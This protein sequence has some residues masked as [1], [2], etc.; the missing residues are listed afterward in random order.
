MTTQ[1]DQTSPIEGV[2][3]YNLF[4]GL[5]FFLLGAGALQAG[6]SWGERAWLFPNVLSTGL[7]VV[8]AVLVVSALLKRGRQRMFPSWGAA[9]DAAWF[10]AAVV[11][12]FV[13]LGGL[14]Y[15]VATITFMFAVSLVL[16][17]RPTLLSLAIKLLSSAA[18]AMALYALF[19]LLLNVP[20]PEGTWL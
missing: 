7:I 17:G 12:Y 4:S 2:L 5:A 16:G 1:T 3:N 9:V 19:A 10:I 13:I 18:G 15:L 6:G 8:G 11:G 14:G 20:L